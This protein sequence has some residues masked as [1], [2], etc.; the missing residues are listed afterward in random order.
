MTTQKETTMSRR[1]LAR[2][3][4]V[5][6]RHL[7][8]LPRVQVDQESCRAFQV[9]PPHILY[10]HLTSSF[11]PSTA[12]CNRRCRRRP[13]IAERKEETCLLSPLPSSSWDFCFCLRTKRLRL[14]LPHNSGMVGRRVPSPHFRHLTFPRRVCRGC[15]R[16]TRNVRCTPLS[17]CEK[18]GSCVNE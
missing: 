2:Y 4:G 7:C 8:V 18:R 5:P 3:T 11:F 17:M 14:P 16:N 13:P 6:P 15:H 12:R 1:Q 9:F 10:I